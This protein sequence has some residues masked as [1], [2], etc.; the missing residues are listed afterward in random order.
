MHLISNE[1]KKIIESHLEELLHNLYEK[2]IKG[3]SNFKTTEELAEKYLK[4]EGKLEDKI[5]K[6]IKNH[7]YKSGLDGFINGVGGAITLPLTIP[8]ELGSLLYYQIRMVSTIALMCGHDIHDSNT[9][10]LTFI[11]L[12]G[13]NHTKFMKEIDEEHNK[14]LLN[15]QLISYSQELITQ[16]N[17]RVTFQLLKK[18]ELQGFL[19]FSKG[20]PIISGL[21]GGALDVISTMKIGEIAKDHFLNN[22]KS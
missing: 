1:H 6:L 11:F 4:D 5:N 7:E 8:L 2:S 22:L 13:D 14:S 9:K 21:L 19:D 15:S 20:I 10:T 17:K 16:I 3:I 12:T 18:L